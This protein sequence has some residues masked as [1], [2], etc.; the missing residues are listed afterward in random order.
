MNICLKNYRNFIKKKHED[1]SINSC[2]NYLNYINKNILTSLNYFK[3]KEI[4]DCV[5]KIEK[6]IIK[7]FINHS[8][9]F[10]SIINHKNNHVH[11]ISRLG[12]IHQKGKCTTLVEYENKK[13]IVKPVH[14]SFLEVINNLLSLFN[15]SK[16]FEFYIL[17]I[18][19]NNSA[20][21]KVEYIDNDKSINKEKFSYHYGALIFIL[22][23]LRG[24]DFHSDNIF[25]VSST[26]VVV[27]C[28]SLFYPIIQ[29]IKSYDITATSL[30]PT[31]FHSKS[32]MENLSLSKDNI[33]NGIQKAYKLIKSNK[34]YLIGIIKDNYQLNC[35]LIFKPTH[36][37]YSLL[38]NSTHSILLVNP[39]K[40]INYLKKSLQGNHKIY[41]AII[42]S[43]LDDLFRLEIPYFS[44]DD[45][46]LFNSK[47]LEIHQNF[48]TSSLDEIMKY[49]ENLDN[50]K[51][52]LIQKITLL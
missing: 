40:R 20:Y 24:V 30:I 43:E 42:S 16:N 23:L 36:Y 2:I 28:E 37:Y 29:D 19:S 38:A 21:S 11:C 33:I 17:K 41:K 27:D 3:N 32:I 22:V 35:R 49:I 15:N 1:F 18:I 46:K 51:H 14:L 9:Y 26:P 52:K 10:K 8:N 7:F 39:E 48:I 45:G 31:S 5:S 13:I 44:F 12:D 34:E 4:K 47:K 25:C 50:F 6:I